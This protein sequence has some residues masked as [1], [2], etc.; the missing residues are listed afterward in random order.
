MRYKPLSWRDPRILI[1]GTLALQLFLSA[2]NAPLR[3][4]ISPPATST[5]PFRDIHR[6]ATAAE[7]F[8]VAL[9]AAKAWQQDA[10]WYG[11]VPFTSIERA[12]VIPLE[13]DNPSWYFRFG[14]PGTGME[15]IVEVRD[16]K[17]VGTNETRLPGY[18]EPLLESLEPLGEQ[19]NMMDNVTALQ[20][21]VEEGCPLAQFPYMVI[22][23]R[24]AKPK[25]LVNP[26]WTL[27]NAHDLSRPIFAI[28]AVT[29]ESISLEGQ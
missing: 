13:D 6:S 8:P 14:I 3:S 12:F 22:D 29:G 5:P 16:G 23:Y 15:Y 1:M 7:S 11:V 21:C 28:D 24:L 25:G 10:R 27:Y 26:I 2:C 20:V 19:W 4:A 18:I 9:E 17:V